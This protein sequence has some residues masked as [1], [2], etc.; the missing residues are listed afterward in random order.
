MSAQENDLFKPIQRDGRTERQDD[1]FVNQSRLRDLESTGAIEHCIF[2]CE[3]KQS[4]Q[5]ERL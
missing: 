1:N 5:E 2:L 3:V 4:A